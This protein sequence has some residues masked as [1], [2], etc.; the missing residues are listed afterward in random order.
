MEKIAFELPLRHTNVLAEKTAHFPTALLN[1]SDSLLQASPLALPFIEKEM[2]ACLLANTLNFAQDPHQILREAHRVL[3]DDGWIFI[4]LFSPMSP[5]LFKSKLGDFKFRQYATWRVIDWLSLLN[6]D[7]IAEEKTIHK[8]REEL[9]LL[10]AHC[11]RCPK[12]NL[13]LNTES[14]ESAIKKCRRFLEP[15]SAFKEIRTE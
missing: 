2:D 15:A 12:T 4:T 11:D 6:F 9:A 14:G 3:K 10:S 13:S 1:E 7:V 5:L 8:T